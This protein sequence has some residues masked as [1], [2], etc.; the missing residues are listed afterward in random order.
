[1]KY[2]LLFGLIVTGSVGNADSLVNCSTV[3]KKPKKV[4]EYLVRDTPSARLNSGVFYMV[5]DEVIPFDRNAVAQYKSTNKELFLMIDNLSQEIVIVMQ[6]RKHGKPN[7]YL[8]R[9]LEMDPTNGKTI[10][11]TEVACIFTVP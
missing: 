8:G 9:V 2:I 4:V 6:A 5:N 7:R 11:K 1:M 3:G 10:R